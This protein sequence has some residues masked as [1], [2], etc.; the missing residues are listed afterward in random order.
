MRKSKKAR[1]QQSFSEND[2][3]YWEPANNRHLS[4]K[5]KHARKLFNDSK[6]KKFTRKEF[7]STRK[8]K[9]FFTAKEAC[10]YLGVH[11]N[12]LAEMVG[13]LKGYPKLRCEHNLRHEN[14]KNMIHTISFRRPDL[15]NYRWHWDREF[16]DWPW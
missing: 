5:E 6:E 2:F 8:S 16:R 13:G 1:T 9:Q 12:Q 7:R 11:P 10:Q 14:D 15:A 4:S 3:N